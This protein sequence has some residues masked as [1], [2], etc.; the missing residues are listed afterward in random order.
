MNLHGL[1]K[2]RE[3]AG[4]PVRV[5]VIGAGKFA[6]MFF[7]QIPTTPGLH[8]VTVVDL[9]VE[10][11]KASLART[12]WDEE[13]FSATSTAD[14][15]SSGRTYLTTDV[16]ELFDCPDIEVVV[17]VT[18]NPIAGT[19]HALGAIA[20]RKHVVMVNVEADAFVGPLLREKAD[21]AG[22]IYSLAYGD[23]PALICEMV[24]WARAI[25]LRVVSAGKGTKYLPEYRRST[26]ETVWDHYGFTD[27]Q[28]ARGD[29]N[30]KMF[31]SFLDGTKSAI[32]M[33]ALANATGLA[34]PEEGLEFPPV[35]ALNLASELRPMSVGGVL[36]RSGMVEVVSSLHRDGSQVDNDLRWGVYVTFE[37]LNDYAA[38]C[39]AEYGLQTDE[40][41]R[42]GALYRP[43]HLIGLELGVSVASIATRGEPTGRPVA[44]VGDVA[45][46]AKRDLRVGDELDGE[47]GYL[48]VG[49]VI[50]ARKSLEIGALPLGL[51]GGGAVLLRDVAEGEIIR[52]E[53][54]D[55]PS[56]NEAI[57]LRREMEQ[58]WGEKVLG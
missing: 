34:V 36:P 39:F 31:N 11:A 46:R 41:G 20:A 32:E 14:A 9:D 19:H 16:S 22:V 55:L 12:G 56:D 53:D 28:L 45:A 15:L 51:A 17:E 4:T 24:D 49:E 48:V 33:A 26:P 37:A 54:V 1:L 47:G 43:Y 27:E 40:T 57:R 3:R 18:G 30:P 5:G 42:Y 23:Q 35:S 21:E 50:P 52:W 13:D 29:F 7:S 38:N 25:G 58:Q 2:D 44:F 8:L 6:S 10:R